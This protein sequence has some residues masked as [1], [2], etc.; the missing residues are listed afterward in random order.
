MQKPEVTISFIKEWL[1]DNSSKRLIDLDINLQKASEYISFAAMK[2][3]A[4][5]PDDYSDAA[6]NYKA[7]EIAETAAA[8]AA[9]FNCVDRASKAVKEYEELT[10]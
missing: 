4:A 6:D 7:A 3:S 5:S 2:A 1:A 8:Y 9:I 10:K